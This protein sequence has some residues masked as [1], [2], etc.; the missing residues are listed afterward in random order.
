MGSSPSTFLESL[1]TLPVSVD[2]DWANLL[3]FDA[4]HVGQEGHD[5]FLDT[6]F[7]AMPSAE[8]DPSLTSGAVSFTVCKHMYII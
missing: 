6:T 7:M 3:H 1:K 4:V 2:N 5:M 8:N